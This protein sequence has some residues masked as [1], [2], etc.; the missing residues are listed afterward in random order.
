MRKN[1]IQTISPFLDKSLEC[2][3]EKNF[4]FFAIC[5]AINNGAG[6]AFIM[7]ETA[8]VIKRLFPIHSEFSERQWIRAACK[9]PVQMLRCRQK[10]STPLLRR[11]R[12]RSKNATDGTANHLNHG[13]KQIT[14]MTRINFYF[15]SDFK[16]S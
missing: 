2:L 7:T 5:S 3:L 12:G 13:F 10:R 9:S 6:S 15:S 11:G 14:R 1:Y 8:G 4:E 16:K